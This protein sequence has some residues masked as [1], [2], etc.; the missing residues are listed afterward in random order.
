M[1][2]V[3][4]L[5]VATLGATVVISS[6]PVQPPPP[7]LTVPI[8]SIGDAVSYGARA[9]HAFGWDYR[10]EDENSTAQDAFVLNVE[11]MQDAIDLAGARHRVL[12]AYSTGGM[13]PGGTTHQRTEY[14]DLATRDAVRI[15]TDWQAPDGTLGTLAWFGPLFTNPPGPD[16]HD[17]RFT[18]ANLSYF[19]FQGRTFTLGDDLSD[20]R[21]PGIVSTVLDMG[22]PRSIRVSS[23]VDRLGSLDGRPLLGITDAWVVEE[24]E[25][26]RT[27]RGRQVTWVSETLPYPVRIEHTWWRDWP[28]VAGW[29]SGF[30][31][32]NRTTDLRGWVPGGGGPIPWTESATPR[33]APA[34]EWSRAPSW[35]PQEGT[36]SRLPIDLRR[37][38][39]SVVD[40]VTLAAFAGWRQENPGWTLAGIDMRPGPVAGFN[41]LPG[42]ILDLTYAAPGGETSFRVRSTYADP[43]LPPRNDNEHVL[44]L[45]TADWDIRLP[46]EEPRQRPVTFGQIDD[47]WRSVGQPE[48]TANTPDRLQWG[49]GLYPECNTDEGVLVVCFAG[50]AHYILGVVKYGRDR[51][52]YAEMPVDNPVGFEYDLIEYDIRDNRLIHSWRGRLDCGITPLLS[53]PQMGPVQA[54][55]AAAPQ[56]VIDLETAA[57]LAAGALVAAAI[58]L[59][60]GTI[61]AWLAKAAVFT[62]FSRLD[63]PDV[64]GHPTRDAIL[65]LVKATP[66]LNVT[67]VAAALPA[68]GWST[69][70]Y[71][72]GVLAKN[73]LLAVVVDGRHRRFFPIEIDALGRK[74]R[75]ALMN[76]KTRAIHEHLLHGSP[77]TR[78][79]LARHLG[80]TVQGVSWHLDRLR[81]AGLLEALGERPVA[82]RARAGPANV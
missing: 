39:Q 37:A 70:V 51:G 27:H 7:S 15:D 41:S 82:Y 62:G 48:M 35:L 33:P 59:F 16:G 8:G 24:T 21:G 65:E 71:H 69:V 9:D 36:G 60:F 38:S 49:Y 75:T 40:D 67:Q 3:G 25:L 13:L 80:I 12:K 76:D 28:D 5:L 6:T 55:A 32:N 57:W 2:V 42:Y 73:R 74:Q 52:V 56:P 58:L 61:K 64:V 81:R 34:A 45:V 78:Q 22:T 14:V 53:E 1:V 20:E 43:R 10:L 31:S 54:R 11:S 46:V 29:P 66:G 50:P 72:L 23:H 30:E 18:H 17:F 44:G 79:E 47:V 68:V 26:Q 4:L 77:M 19:A 63:E